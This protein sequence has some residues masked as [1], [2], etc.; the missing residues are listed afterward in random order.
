MC[1]QIECNEKNPKLRDNLQNNLPVMKFQ[2]HKCQEQA[3]QKKL[4]RYFNKM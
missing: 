4:R 3:Y 1:L 2:D